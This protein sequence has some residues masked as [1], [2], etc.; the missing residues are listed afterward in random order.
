MGVCANA[1]GVIA[2]GVS[3]TV[4]NSNNDVAVITIRTCSVFETE[5]S[6]NLSGT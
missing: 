2:A 3:H 4:V 1:A 5:G 6:F